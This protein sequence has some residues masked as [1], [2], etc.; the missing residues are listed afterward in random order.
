M[1]TASYRLIDYSLRPG[2]YAERKMLVEAF[3][4]LKS[5]G[6]LS[7]YQYIGFGSIW[8]SD[9]ILIHKALGIGDLV[10][11]EQEKDHEA[12][13]NFNKPF[14]G[15]TLRMGHSAEVLPSLDWNR[16]SIVWLDYDD[17]LNTGI[18]DDVRTV[19]SRISSG[20]A[21]AVSVQAEKIFAPVVD[22]AGSLHVD[23]GEKFLNYFGPARTP[24]EI[25]PPDLRGWT[26][27]ATSRKV[28][29]QEI[30]SALAVIN[31]TRNPGN[32]MEFRPVSA[33]EYADGAKMTTICGVFIDVG[34]RGHFESC[35]FASL[36]F[37]KADQ[38]ACRI[39]VPLIT[40]REM[41]HLD[42]SLP[43]RP[44]VAIQ[45]GSVPG[46]DARLY[47]ELYRYLPNFASF[48]V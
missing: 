7:S 15:I 22:G 19:S 2:K 40:P 12:R 4:R 25:G 17:P 44:G 39:E 23:D 3:A 38:S 20:S 31:A 43:V 18:L 48:E 37:V 5:F 28:I 30:R 13:F 6:D 26:L 10:S 33:F 24:P 27:S 11:I 8:F 9:C 47:S 45:N 14:G 35:N 29:L 46:R 16:R 1:S 34:Q 36:P 21:L 42:L 41:R 32:H